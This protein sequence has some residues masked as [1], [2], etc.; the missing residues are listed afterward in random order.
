MAKWLDLPVVLLANAKAQS[1]SLAALAKGF[2]EFDR[3]LSWVGLVANQVGSPSHARILG[4][5]MQAVPELAF[6]GGLSRQDDLSLPERHLGLVTALETGFSEDL[7]E[8]LASW[9]ENALDLDVFLANLPETSLRESKINTTASGVKE[10]VRLGVAW[11]KAFCFYYQENLRRLEEAGAE[12]VFFSPLK[13][14]F[15]PPGLNGLYLGGGY[16]ELFCAELADN[17]SLQKEIAHLASFGMPIYAEC[18]GMMYLAQEIRDL[19]GKSWPMAGVL[20]FKADMLPRLRS[21]GYRTVHFTTDTVLG[22][23]GT[24]ARGHEFHYS[25]ISDSGE[26][27]P[28]SEYLGKGGLVNAYE[29]GSRLGLRPETH[30]YSQ[31]NLLASYVHLHF[32]S[33]PELASGFVSLMKGQRKIA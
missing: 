3:E 5:A 11:D 2:F 19:K 7:R 29:V 31:K 15:L 22:P 28:Q 30:G 23:A 21:L 1:R 25:E 17:K 16:P 6:L 9:L 14:K 26:L 24:R 4:Q 8:R 18:G 32:G 27:I 33:N 12:L 20:P 10:K 13:D